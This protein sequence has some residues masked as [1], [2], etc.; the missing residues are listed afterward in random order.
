MPLVEPNTGAVRAV[1]QTRVS[2]RQSWLDD[3]QVV[4]YL[5]VEKLELH[6]A[7][8]MSGAQLVW[9]YGQILQHDQLAFAHFNRGDNFYDW[10]VRI[11][12]LD[13][14][15]LVDDNG[16]PDEEGKPKVI[17]TWV[18]V[19]VGDDDDQFGAYVYQQNNQQA[20]L[21]AGRQRITALG[22]E[23]LLHRQPML[24]SYVKDVV[25]SQGGGELLID[26]AIDFNAATLDN[27]GGNRSDAFGSFDRLF[28]NQPS[29]G[30]TWSSREIVSYVVK[31]LG[32]RSTADAA[33]IGFVPVNLE[34]LPQND[35]PP[36]RTYGKTG[37][38]I[39]NE[40][41]NRRRA[42]TFYAA[43]HADDPGRV[44]LKCVS[45]LDDFLVLEDDVLSANI[46]G[47]D[48]DY[49][50]A[51][52]VVRA[53]V[54]RTTAN[55]YDRVVVRGARA[56]SIFTISTIDATLEADWLSADETAYEAGPSG[57]GGLDVD[58]QERRIR[59]FRAADRFRDVFARFKIPDDWDFTVQDGEGN[60]GGPLGGYP[61]LDI[62]DVKE[63]YRPDLRFLRKLPIAIDATAD[64]PTAAYSRLGTPPLVF[65]K[66]PDD[67]SMADRYGQVERLADAAGVEFA[68]DEEGRRW[69]CNVTL[70]D[71]DLAFVVRVSGAPQHVIADNHFTPLSTDEK[72]TLQ[73]DYADNLLATMAVELDQYCEGVWP[74]VPEGLTDAQRVLFVNAGDAYRLDYVCEQTVLAVVDGVPKRIAAPKYV[75]DDRGLLLDIAKQAHAWHA[76]DRRA[77][78]LEFRQV[79]DYV[80]LGALVATI[81]DG[82]TEQQVNTVATSIV[83][84]FTRG[85]TTIST[86]FA[87]LESRGLAQ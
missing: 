17:H 40:A 1:E 14:N 36:I 7:P 41:A 84:D 72:D 46:P 8:Q 53:S 42:F 61:L 19:L 2:I 18:G 30:Q 52:D 77:I 47:Y 69:S 66:L 27:E 9:E 80:P 58:K 48:L 51:V 73:V 76:R 85:T 39:I 3:W 60:G 82:A 70:A 12:V 57:I 37:W 10:F 75:R 28:S 81:N 35:S 56:R 49:D 34:A 5:W 4:P 65:L 67:E 25:G 45:L 71:D 79:Q 33:I 26:R 68:G 21:A 62:L 54:R 32:P 20:R 55:R 43:L 63:Q 78:V 50:R 29:S 86:D 23:S 64:P 24:R 87:D 31:T 15:Q 13:P 6:C 16:E 22:L 38:E 74:Q 59:E 83:W 11:E 44:A